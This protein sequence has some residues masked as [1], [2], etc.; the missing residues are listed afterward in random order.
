MGPLEKALQTLP[1][2]SLRHTGNWESTMEPGG[3]EVAVGCI[4]LASMLEVRLLAG[5]QK[6]CN[7]KVAPSAILQQF[8]GPTTAFEVEGNH[9]G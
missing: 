7:N 6:K 4:K 5:E 8:Q 1:Y 3:Q 2:Q 9:H